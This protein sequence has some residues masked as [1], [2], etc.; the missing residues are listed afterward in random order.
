M[1]ARK[2]V[3]NDLPVGEANLAQIRAGGEGA[4]SVEGKRLARS[5]GRLSKLA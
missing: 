2:P 4:H 3:V 1:Q 5:I